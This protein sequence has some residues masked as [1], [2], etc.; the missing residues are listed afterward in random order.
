MQ[1]NVKKIYLSTAVSPSAGRSAAHGGPLAAGAFPASVSVRVW[2][3]FSFSVSVRDSLSF[4][5]SF[6]Y[7]YSGREEYFPAAARRE[8]PRIETAV[9]LWYTHSAE[10]GSR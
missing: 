5:L 9:E 4:S 8:S 1:Q 2:G 7:S 3:S 10:R 6:S